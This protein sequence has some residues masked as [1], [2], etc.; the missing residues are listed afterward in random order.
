MIRRSLLAIALLLLP[1]A[2]VSA[3][4]QSGQVQIPLDIYEKLLEQ[5]RQPDAGPPLNV[6]LS[7]A[8]V[9]VRVPATEPRATA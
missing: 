8:R 3:Q 9:Q 5:V 4:D 1:L 7:S 2:A 6:A